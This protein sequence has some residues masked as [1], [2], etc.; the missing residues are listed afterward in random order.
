MSIRTVR[1]LVTE[2]FWFTAGTLPK[3]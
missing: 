2:D 1:V 3:P